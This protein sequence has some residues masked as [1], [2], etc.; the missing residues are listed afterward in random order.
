MCSWSHL[1]SVYRYHTDIVSWQISISRKGQRRDGKCAPTF[2]QVSLMET[3]PS[4]LVRTHTNLAKQ[5]T[6]WALLL[7][8][9]FRKNRTAEDCKVVP[10]KVTKK[11]TGAQRQ[12]CVYQWSA[13]QPKE[14]K[15]GN[16]TI[17]FHASNKWIYHNVSAPARFKESNSQREP[18]PR[19][20]E[21][22][23]VRTP[24]PRGAKPTPAFC[25]IPTPLNMSPHLLGSP[26]F[27]RSSQESTLFIPPVSS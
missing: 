10:R 25:N 6:I 14:S 2:R 20:P 13:N 12:R 9:G 24:S 5:S 19:I 7:E 11:E 22:F 1:G 23:V 16:F 26:T 8:R 3:N 21:G 4:L 15:E 17:W 18:S 27:L